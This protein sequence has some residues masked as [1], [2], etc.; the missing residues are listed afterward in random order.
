MGC[1]PSESFLQSTLECFYNYSCINIIQTQTNSSYEMNSPP[2][3]TG[4][5]RFPIN[6]TI[7]DLVND[8]FVENWLTAVNYSLYFDQCS[9]KLCS[10]TYIQ[11]LNSFYTVTSVLSISGGIMFILKWISP[12]LVRLLVA[13]NRYRKKRTNVVQCE[14]N[15]PMTTITTVDIM[16]RQMNIQPEAINL[17]S[18]SNDLPPPTHCGSFLLCFRELICWIILIFVVLFMIVLSFLTIIP[19]AKNEAVISAPFIN[20]TA[21][22]NITQKLTTSISTTIASSTG[23]KTKTVLF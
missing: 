12:I 16:P 22:N 13:I 14:S 17:Q 4:G 6:T 11:E 21:T 9:P 18:E 15:I 1:T 19:H 23:L 3:I 7:N 20:T 10:Y 2:L 8:L 5:S